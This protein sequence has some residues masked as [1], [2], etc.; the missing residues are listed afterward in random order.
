MA[1]KLQGYAGATPKEVEQ[2]SLAARMTLRP[3][4]LGV[5]GNSF[6]LSLQT[7]GLPVA[8]ANAHIFAARY[9]PSGSKLALLR[10]LSIAMVSTTTPTAGLI[11]A[12]LFRATAWTVSDTG[13]SSAAP[14]TQ[15]SVANLANASVF[16]DLRISSTAALTAGNETLDTAPLAAALTYTAA[17]IGQ[18]IPRTAIVDRRA[19]DQPLVL[20][21]TQGI[22]LV[23]TAPNATWNFAVDMEW[24]EVTSFGTAL[25]A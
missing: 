23:V 9:A 16:A 7:G 6:S 13:G 24:D 15:N 3:M 5:S 17:V 2:G 25:A 8:L 12:Q 19:A 11:S 14:L 1:I 20:A 10:R 18:A 4:D 21:A 22:V